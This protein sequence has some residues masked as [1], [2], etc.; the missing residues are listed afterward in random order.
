MLGVFFEPDGEAVGALQ[1]NWNEI[2]GL[3]QAVIR[4]RAG[5]SEESFAGI[6]EAFSAETGDAKIVISTFEQEQREPVA[7]DAE[8][9]ADRGDIREDIKSCRGR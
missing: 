1:G 7:R 2:Q 4:F 6:A 8:P 5:K 9:I 3:L